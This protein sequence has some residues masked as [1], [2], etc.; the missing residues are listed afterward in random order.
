MNVIGVP[1][2]SLGS[3]GRIFA[4]AGETFAGLATNVLAE[5]SA[6]RDEESLPYDPW[7][8]DDV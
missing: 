5:L 3:L 4:R 6:D 2:N 7:L 1:L 8:V